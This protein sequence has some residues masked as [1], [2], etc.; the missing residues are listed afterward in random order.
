V[1][2]V[3][4]GVSDFLWQPIEGVASGSALGLG[5]ARKTTTLHS[6]SFRLARLS[7]L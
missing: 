4:G 7:A 5:A 3:G 1:R 6:K 2:S